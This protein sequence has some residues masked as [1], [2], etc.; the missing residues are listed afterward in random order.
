MAGDIYGDA[1]LMEYTDRN[2]ITWLEIKDPV[3]IT[4]SGKGYCDYAESFMVIP[5]SGA[6]AVSCFVDIYINIRVNKDLD[7]Q[8]KI[9]PEIISNSG[10]YAGIFFNQM[11]FGTSKAPWHYPSIMVVYPKYFELRSVQNANNLTFVCGNV[12]ISG[13]PNRGADYGNGA[14]HIDQDGLSLTVMHRGSGNDS[15]HQVWGGYGTSEWVNSGTIYNWKIGEGCEC[16]SVGIDQKGS[17]SWIHS[18]AWIPI[19]NLATDFNWSED[20]ENYDG[21]IYICGTGYYDDLIVDHPST[22]IPRAITIPGLKRLLNYYPWSICKNGIYYSC[23][24]PG[25][26]MQSRKSGTYVD[27]KNRPD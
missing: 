8:M 26:C 9:V 12:S 24:R 11:R 20:K 10:G 3:H 14:K 25:G 21:T 5:G 7:V 16:D 18:S 22:A 15:T 4:Q 1:G 23:N 6:G 13:V 17:E 2:G 19:G 27:R